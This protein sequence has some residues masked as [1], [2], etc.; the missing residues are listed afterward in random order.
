M[1][2]R[3]HSRRDFTKSLAFLAAAPMTAYADENAEPVDAGLT[4]AQA[5]T[6]IVRLR[7]GKHLSPEQLDEVKKSIERSLRSADQLKQFKL[8]NSDEPAFTFSAELP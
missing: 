4:P 7:H 5:L 6:D 3:A 1:N 8:Q 2:Q